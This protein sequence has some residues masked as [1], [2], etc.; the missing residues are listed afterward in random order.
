VVRRPDAGVKFGKATFAGDGGKKA[1]SPG[2]ARYK[3]LKPLRRKAGSFGEPV[4]TTLVCLFYFAREAAGAAGTRLSLR[5]L[6]SWANGHAQPDAFAPRNAESYPSRSMPPAWI[7]CGKAYDWTRGALTQRPILFNRREDLMYAAIRQAKAKTGTAEEL[8]RRIKEGPFRSS[9]MLK[10]S[11]P[12][13]SS[14][15]RTTL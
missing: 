4:V 12:I 3:L 5:P 15:H 9:V 13:M 10:A 11:W 7:N 8:A 2:R 6:F 14:M 1:R